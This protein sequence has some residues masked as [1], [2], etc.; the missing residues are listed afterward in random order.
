MQNE[1]TKI[2]DCFYR[3]SAKALILDDEKRFLLVL[4]DKGLWE[5]P[6]GGLDFGEKPLECLAR[7][8]REE[9]G[10]EV[11]SVKEQPAYFLTAPV[12][13]GQWWTANVIY[14]A[15]VKNLDFKPSDECVELRFFTKEEA[16][17]EKLFPNVAEFVK[18]YNP[19]KH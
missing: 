9:M 14:E 4:E 3:I 16:L 19:D 5:L 7:E 8:I 1:I 11:V 17:Q 2:P 13:S 6:G 15:K 10:L 18:I 12:R